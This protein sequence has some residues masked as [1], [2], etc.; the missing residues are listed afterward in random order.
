MRWGKWPAQNTPMKHS[1][2][3]NSPPKFK[4]DVYFHMHVNI[5]A[6]KRAGE[7]SSGPGSLHRFH[8][9]TLIPC[10]LTHCTTGRVESSWLCSL[11]RGIMGDQTDIGQQKTTC[12]RRALNQRKLVHVLHICILTFLYLSI[13]QE[14]EKQHKIVKSNIRHSSYLLSREEN[15]KHT[16]EWIN[17]R[18]QPISGPSL[19]IQGHSCQSKENS[20]VEYLY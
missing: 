3:E 18:W 17:C 6:L 13:Y 14:L 16:E 8:I 12:T 9:Q 7:P 20:K 15:F 2:D 1:Q 4:H 10:L 11:N 19:I 5:W